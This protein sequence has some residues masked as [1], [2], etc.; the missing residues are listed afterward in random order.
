MT[1]QKYDFFLAIQSLMQMDGVS[2]NVTIL[3]LAS[4]TLMEE[5]HLFQIKRGGAGVRSAMGAMMDIYNSKSCECCLFLLS[6]N[7]RL[8]L[9][10]H[11]KLRAPSI[12]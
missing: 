12:F 3:A 4:L 5:T 10:A 1:I 7:M 9:L 8:I 11:F 2:L 6:C